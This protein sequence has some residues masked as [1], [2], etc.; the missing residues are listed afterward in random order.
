MPKPAK[1]AADSKPK[2]GRKA[3][4]LLDNLQSKLNITRRQAARLKKSGVTEEEV[5]SVEAAKLRKLRLEGDKL[6]MQ[7]A[8]LRRDYF[9]KDKIYEH[10]LTAF[11]VF[12]SELLQFE[13]TFPPMLS[14]LTAQEMK[15]KIRAAIESALNDL[16]RREWP[17]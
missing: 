11:T 10:F 12:K 13:T 16:S 8:I 4:P 15:P 7:L 14:G 5:D 1:S 17:E 2:R 3:D 9:P 6:E